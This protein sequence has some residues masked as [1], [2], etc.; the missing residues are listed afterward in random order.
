MQENNN[1]QKDSIAQDDYYAD[2]LEFFSNRISALRVSKDVSAREMSL[3]IGQDGGYIT[4]LERKNFLPSMTCFLSICDY[5]KISPKDFFDDGIEY[6]G[7][8][9]KLIERSKCLTEKQLRLLSDL[10]ESFEK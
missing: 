1:M 2:Y 5:L 9:S 7:V 8:L 4:K 10:L 6:P 3:S